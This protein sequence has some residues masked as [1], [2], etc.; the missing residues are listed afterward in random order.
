MLMMRLLLLFLLVFGLQFTAVNAHAYPTPE[1]K[2]ASWTMQ[3]KGIKHVFNAQNKVLHLNSEVRLQSLTVYNILGQEAYRTTLGGLQS[4][5]N[6]SALQKGMY[7]AKIKASN[8]VTKTFK[9]VVR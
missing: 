1:N 4:R 9:L 5:V 8:N 2:V 6:L 3:S 7:I